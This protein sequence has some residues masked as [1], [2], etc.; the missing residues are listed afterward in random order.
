MN[1]IFLGRDACMTAAHSDASGILVDRRFLVDCGYFV[2]DR[3]ITL[4][5]QPQEI[6]TVLF[7]H[8]HHDHYFGLPQ[9]LFWYLQT[10]KPLERLNLYG[11]ERDLLRVVDLSKAYL[12]AGEGRGFY[13][14]CGHPTLHPLPAK[15]SFELPEQ[16]TAV[17]DSLPA[18]EISSA[19]GY[20]V[21]TC[22]SY[23]PVDGL[24]YRI[25]DR[26]G[27]VLS[28]TGDTFWREDIPET[29]AD[30]DLLVHE[31]ALA[32]G[33]ADLANPPACLHSNIDIAVRTAR[34]AR[35]KRLFVVHFPESKKVEVQRRATE[36]GFEAVYPELLYEYEV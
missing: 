7:S 14:N 34:E 13:E 4:G 9:L 18:V 32:A 10:G 26:E 27:K 33:T 1:V 8:M 22:A 23:H 15:S 3:L 36:L 25:A 31:T 6:E 2:A 35:A 20:K 19:A 30:C 24:C 28:L 21:T 5:I 29:L 17:S 16:M 11:P 12:Q